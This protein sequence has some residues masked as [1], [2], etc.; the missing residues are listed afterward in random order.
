MDFHCEKS[1]NSWT[2]GNILNTGWLTGL[3]D[4]DTSK[5]FVRTRIADYLKDLLSIGFSGFRVDAILSRIRKVIQNDDHDQQND[6]SSLRDMHDNGCVLVKGCDANTHW[7]FEIRLFTDPY[8][9]A[10]NDN[11][12][13]IRMLLSSFYFQ[14][15]V[16]VIPDGKSD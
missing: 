10:D 14:D 2:D 12:Y 1:L 11:D 8:G 16:Q 7:N 9:G 6:G 4:L 3:T 13:P 5:E 15:G